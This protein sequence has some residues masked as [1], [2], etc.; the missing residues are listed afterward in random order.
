MRGKTIAT[1]L[2]LTSIPLAALLCFAG[3]AAAAQSTDKPLKEQIDVLNQQVE[4]KKN[5]LRDLEVK[6]AQYKETINQKK[7][8]AQSL[9]DEMALLDNRIAKTAL[10]IEIA[11]NEIGALELEITGYERDIADK[12]KRVEKERRLLGD[13]ARKLYRAETSRSTLELVLSFRSFSDFFDGLRAMMSLQDGVRRTLDTVVALQQELTADKHSRQDKKAQAAIRKSELEAAQASLD[14]ERAL[15]DALITETKSSELHYRYLLADLKH[16]QLQADT[17]IEY[18]E[19]VLRQKTDLA[20]R[21]KGESPIL[22]WPVV[23]ARGVA[24]WFHDPEYPFRYVF[25]HPGVDIRCGQGTPVRAA[26][27]GVIGR[28]KNA[29]LGYSYVLIIHNNDISTVYGHLS[30]IVAR[31]DAFVER[32]EIIGYSGGMPGTSGAGPMT[33]G[34]HL[35]FETRLG[36]LPQDPMNF[37]MRL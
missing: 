26:A 36:G 6:T 2:I 19:K 3:T 4:Q 23:P 18:L 31:E 28:A 12:E 29:G 27:S 35:H 8:Q 30:K 10:S 9:E 7:Q 25:E 22:S 21:V 1:A 16:E 5:S 24:T 14:D 11:K 32:G 37:L 15:K 17:E 34:P 33:T 13:L 20:A